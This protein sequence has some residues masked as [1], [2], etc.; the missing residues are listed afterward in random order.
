MYN[1]LLQQQQQQSGD[2]CKTSNPCGDGESCRPCRNTKGYCCDAQALP[3]QRACAPGSKNQCP[4]GYSCLPV[5]QHL[6]TEEPF[7]ADGHLIQPPQIYDGLMPP[8]A[9]V[10]TAKHYSRT[11]YASRKLRTGYGASSYKCQIR[12]VTCE[13]CVKSKGNY[14]FG[15]H[16]IVSGEPMVMDAPMTSTVKQCRKNTAM[17]NARCSQYKNCD[18]CTSQAKDKTYGQL[19]AWAPGSGGNYGTCI[20]NQVSFWRRP[21]ITDSSKCDG[22]IQVSD[23]VPE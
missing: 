23:D 4:E 13:L 1:S 11:G 19:C 2:I 9:P 21:I 15:S 20:Q 8:V 14:W 10:A 7:H 3:V 22:I 17:D 18:V 6:V 5:S 12:P 16:C